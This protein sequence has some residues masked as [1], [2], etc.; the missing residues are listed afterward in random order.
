MGL[1]SFKALGGAFAASRL[2]AQYGQGVTLCCASAGN[3]GLSV[4]AGAKI[5][6]AKAVIFLAETVPLVFEEKLLAWDAEIIRIGADYEA[7]S[8]AAE[9][10]S[11]EN[12]WV[13]LADSSWERY[14]QI[15]SWVM[16]GYT[17]IGHELAAQFKKTQDWPSHVFLQAGVG[18]FAAALSWHIR[19]SWSVQP[20]VFIVEPD[21]AACLGESKRIG[22][23]AKAHG[24][25]SIMGRLDCK[26]ASLVAV[27]LLNQYADSFLTVSDQAA[28]EASQMLG[29]CGWPTTPSGAA[30]LAG[31]QLICH[32]LSPEDRPLIVVTEDSL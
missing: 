10:K 8:A 2:V 23:V 15:P 29:Q 17:V 6:G 16:Q 1:G 14:T 7:S 30:G 13:L 27:E 5:F 9:A 20:Q 26:E 31:L 18:G 24:P 22:R 32:Q 25:P 21:S 11:K 3:H 19:T 4:A 28:Q 12:D